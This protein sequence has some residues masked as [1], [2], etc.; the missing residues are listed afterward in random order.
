MLVLAGLAGSASAADELLGAGL[1]PVTRDVLRRAVGY[2]QDGVW[3]K[4]AAAYRV[5]LSKEPEWVQ[6]VLGLGRVLAH[7]GDRAG[8]EAVYRRLPWEPE[9]L[10]AL[11]RLLEPDRPAEALVVYQKLANLRFGWPG[12]WGLQARAALAAEELDTALEAAE[13]YHELSQ[14]RLDADQAGPFLLDLAAALRREGR[15]D[16]ARVWLERA[17]R[18]D[19]EGPL[20]EE[21]AARLDRIAVEEA[22]E[23]LGGARAEAL[24]PARRLRLEEARRALAEGELARAER[25]LASLRSQSPRSPEV[26]A[27]WADLSLARDQ[28]S[29]AEVAWLTAVVLDPE[30]PRWRERLGTLLA[31]RYGGR[32]HREAA[33]ELGVALRKRPTWTRLH[34]QLGVVHQE[35]GE[36]ERA[37]THLEAYLGAEPVGP[38]SADA[39]QR[40]ADLTRV[41]PEPP[42]AETV[43]DAPPP[44]LPLA[45]WEPLRIARVYRDRGDLA[46][47]REELADALAVAPDQPVLLNLAATLLLAEGET[48]QAL[49]AW[50]KSVAV[51]PGQGAVLQE[52]GELHLVRGDEDRARTLF[53]QAVRTDAP[54]GW[55]FLA[56]MAHAQGDWLDARRH[57]QRYFE[58]AASG[59]HHPEAVSLAAQLEQRWQLTLGALSGGAVLALGLPLGLAVRRR[60]GHDLATLLHEH[61]DAA[62][63]AARILSAMRHEVLKHNTTVMPAVADALAQGDPGPALDLKEQLVG[64][65]EVILRWQ[66]YVAE[67]EQLGRSHRLRLNLRHRDPVLG[68]MCAAFR[69]LERLIPGLH[70]RGPDG[71]RELRELSAVL[72]DR[73]YEQLGVL[74]REA[75]VMGLDAQVLGRCWD[76]V[77]GEPSF[78]GCPVPELV[79]EAG[80]E[81]LRVKVSP[82]DLDDVVCNVLRNSLQVVLADHPDGAGRLGLALDEE[83]D[84]VTGLE[85]VALRFRDN[86]ERPL[87]DAMIRGRQISRGLGLTVDLINRHGGSIRVED[88]P[89]WAKAVVVRLPR[90][91][92]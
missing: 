53:R 4:S 90:G 55:F 69:A 86:A 5:V 51:D 42:A 27:A 85:E 70:R 65:G 13:R 14:G 30:D 17:G 15:R 59:P 10:E 45:A 33:E 60:T 12:A 22:A 64:T 6:A 26:Q 28:V 81:P 88:E 57:L 9:A 77:R 52:L 63:D 73:G 46:A 36:F 21:A 58:L 75:G 66:A 44:G 20:A 8:A 62:P 67:L 54:G 11:G 16:E 89:G 49:A 56:A 40:L 47:A 31:T 25:Q 61:P 35:M 87:N 82:H 7:S 41:R 2:E 34:H 71:A 91:E 92:W 18:L 32:R 74:I 43:A 72:N 39:R 29:E 83:L 84:P 78:A 38:W 24:S 80:D 3:A 37:V 79:V 19:P 1:D 76:R 48:D 50:E 23:A 68:P